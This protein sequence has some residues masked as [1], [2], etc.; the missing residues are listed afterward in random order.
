MSCPFTVTRADGT[1]I[2]LKWREKQEKQPIIY[3]NLNTPKRHD[4]VKPKKPQKKVSE[5]EYILKTLK[6]IKKDLQ[7]KY[8]VTFKF[9]K[10]KEIELLSIKLCKPIGCVCDVC[11]CKKDTNI[12]TLN[13]N[14]MM[15]TAN[16]K[17]KKCIS[18]KNITRLKNIV[19]RIEITNKTFIL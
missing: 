9:Y 17:I 8:N 2:Q 19:S 16:S 4:F 13:L 10:F 3:K 6:L 5:K 14:K 18:E 11:D 7:L 1:V 12:Y 15:P